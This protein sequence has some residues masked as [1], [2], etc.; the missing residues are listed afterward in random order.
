MPRDQV[1]VSHNDMIEC[2]ILM[3]LSDNTR[4]ML[5][6]YEFG[7]WNPEYYDLATF[8]NEWSC[9]NAH[10]GTKTSCCIAYYLE[11]WPSEAEVR[12]F[13]RQ[14]FVLLNGIEDGVELAP[15]LAVSFEK[16]VSDV[17]CCMLLN[18]F[19]CAMCPLMMMFEADETDA[20]AFQWEYI[21]GR[22]Q[23]FLKSNELLPPNLRFPCI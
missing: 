22:C 4:L 11:N 19:F 7:M 14:Y 13:T 12:E 3:D 10:P 21:R 15:E 18:N 6:D 8:L 20:T 9:D 5:I 16:A 1:C 2:N 23:L 17:K